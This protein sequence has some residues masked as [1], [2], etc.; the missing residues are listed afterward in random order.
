MSSAMPI[1]QEAALEVVLAGRRRSVYSRFASTFSFSISWLDF[2]FM[3][4]LKV[5]LRPESSELRPTSFLRKY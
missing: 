1:V 4:I 5:G 3:Y 2:T